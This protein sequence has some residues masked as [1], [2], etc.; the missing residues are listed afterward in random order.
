MNAWLP[1]A[2]YP[3]GNFSDTS[4]WKLFKPKGSRGL[5][6]A[7]P[8]RTEHRDQ[9]SFGPY[10][11]REVSGLTELV[12]GHPRYSLMDVPPQSNSPPGYV[13]ETDHTRSISGSGPEWTV[14]GPSPTQEGE[15]PFPPRVQPST[16][17]PYACCEK[18]YQRQD[19]LPDAAPSAQSSKYNNNESSGISL[20]CRNTPTYATPLMSLYVAKLKSSSTGSSFPTDKCKSVPLPAVSPDSR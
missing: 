10:T 19:S 15:N 3:C 4:C 9:T 1:Q 2:S 7:V 6:F 13:L 20:T 5:A 8:V 14:L 11:L 17:S 18:A 12:L 16:P